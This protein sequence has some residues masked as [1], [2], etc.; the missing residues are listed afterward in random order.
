MG[1]FFLVASIIWLAMATKVLYIIPESSSIA[2][3]PSQPCATLSQYLLNNSLISFVSDFNIYLLPGNHRV[4]TDMEM[5]NVS[6]VSLIGINSNVSSLAIL[7]CLSKSHIAFYDSYNIT[8]TNLVFNQCDGK[9]NFIN[10]YYKKNRGNIKA[11]LLLFGCSLCKVQNIIFYG[12]GLIGINLIGKSF[13][14]NITIDLYIAKP[15]FDNDVCTFKIL[16]VYTDEDNN[17]N[18]HNTNEV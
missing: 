8:I 15:H 14:K 12:Y 4:I 9:I 5:W 16:L 1:L 10:K 11:G 17:N 18:T 7:D 13:L 2:K 6:N 3:C